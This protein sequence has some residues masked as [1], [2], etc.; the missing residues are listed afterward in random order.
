LL[1]TYNDHLVQLPNQFRADQKLKQIIKGI[2]QMSLSK[3]DSHGALTTS[4]ESLFQ[5]SKAFLKN[6]VKKS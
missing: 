2:V 1:G 5:C 3:T 6:I 4:L